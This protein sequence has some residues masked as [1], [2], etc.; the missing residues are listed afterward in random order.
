MINNLGYVRGRIQSSPNIMIQ[1][2]SIGACKKDATKLVECL[3][4]PMFIANYST[5]FR[6]ALQKLQETLENNNVDITSEGIGQLIGD[7]LLNMTKDQQESLGTITFQKVIFTLSGNNELIIQPNIK[8]IDAEA[9]GSGEIIVHNGHI[10]SGDFDTTIIAYGPNAMASLTN[11]GHGKAENGA[12]IF[13]RGGYG[14][15]DGVGS[16]GHAYLN[17][18]RSDLTA[19]NGAVV[20]GHG[21]VNNGQ[22]I[23][24]WVDANGE[25]SRATAD[26]HG[27]SV[28]SYNGGNINAINGGTLYIE[29]AHDDSDSNFEIPVADSLNLNWSNGLDEMKT[30]NLTQTIKNIF[31][32]SNIE[33]KLIQDW[34][35][36]PNLKGFTIFLSRIYQI[37][38]I[39]SGSNESKSVAYKKLSDIIQHMDGNYNMRV[40]CEDIANESVGNCQDR[41][42]YGFLR[43]QIADKF[44][45]DSNK[46]GTIFEN[47]KKLTAFNYI[48]QKI[49]QDAIARL[50]NS[51]IENPDDLEIGLLYLKACKDLLGIEISDMAYEYVAQNYFNNTDLMSEEQ[52]IDALIDYMKSPKYD[53]DTYVVIIDLDNR[54]KK[55]YEKQ[56][57]ALTEKFDTKYDNQIEEFSFE[58]LISK[59]N[60]YLN[61]INKKHNELQEAKITF[62]KQQLE[63]EWLVSEIS[64]EEL[65]SGVENLLGTTLSETGQTQDQFEYMIK[66]LALDKIEEKIS[67]LEDVVTDLD[68]FNSCTEGIYWNNNHRISFRHYDD[69]DKS[70]NKIDFNKDQAQIK[71]KLD[72]KNAE[73]TSLKLEFRENTHESIIL[74][75]IL[76]LY[77]KSNQEV[78]SE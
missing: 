65:R 40:I 45:H 13:V 12:A 11:R 53:H 62:I 63:I 36:L 69:H 21:S 59:K 76:Q 52:V 14:I 67:N 9:N 8:L 54:V 58:E 28:A 22:P 57:N 64:S 37:K 60:E 19:T 5:K 71:E 15:A 26:G 61:I 68:N 23:S 43:M 32:E 20:T 7:I 17:E 47:Q 55:R 77:I 18:S 16:I 27:V 46:I 29:A 31:D 66:N 73:L 33:L 48:T 30:I 51:G 50:R 2:S 78:Y 24:V 74:N 49:M 75:N 34:N 72:E 10:S 35:T 4:S 44:D 6:N 3:P 38:D 70:F 39:S 1:Q 56:F 42:N 41:I 25:N